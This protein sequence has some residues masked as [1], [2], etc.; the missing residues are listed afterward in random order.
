[1]EKASDDTMRQFNMGKG[2]FFRYYI[3]FTILCG[4]SIWAKVF[5]LSYYSLLLLLLL[6]SYS[7]HYYYHYYCYYYCYYSCYYYYYYYYVAIVDGKSMRRFCAV[8]QYAHIFFK[9]NC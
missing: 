9:K 6:Y 2:I 4:N 5:Y 1:M 3:L 8:I 7:Y